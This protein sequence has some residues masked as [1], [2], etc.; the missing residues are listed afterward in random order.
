MKSLIIPCINFVDV[1]VFNCA[2]TILKLFEYLHENTTSEPTVRLNV[3]IF[4]TA[5]DIPAFTS[6][7]MVLR[8][9]RYL[10]SGLTDEA[11]RLQAFYKITTIKLRNS[12]NLNKTAAMGPCQGPR[13]ASNYMQVSE[14]DMQKEYSTLLNLVI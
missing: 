6:K 2:Q 12:I 14:S 10:T 7:G 8:L 3:L 4:H 9:T 5:Y 1:T 11:L 13:H